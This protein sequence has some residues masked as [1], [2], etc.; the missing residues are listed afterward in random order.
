MK[1]PL[2]LV[3]GGVEKGEVLGGELAGEEVSVLYRTIIY[4]SQNSPE[5]IMTN[6]MRENF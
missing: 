3:L 4:R 5:P 1:V 6:L 2:L